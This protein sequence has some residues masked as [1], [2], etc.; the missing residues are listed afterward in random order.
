ME[1]A[2]RLDQFGSTGIEIMSDMKSY[3]HNGHTPIVVIHS[4]VDLMAVMFDLQIIGIQFMF[5][6]QR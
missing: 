1:Q 6:V 3:C 2:R 5:Q 4:F